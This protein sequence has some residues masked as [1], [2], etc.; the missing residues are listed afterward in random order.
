MNTYTPDLWC[1]LKT[2]NAS[3]TD[4]AYKILGSWYGGYLNGDSWKLSSG[5]MLAKLDGEY[6]SLVQYSGSTYRVHKNNYGTSGYTSS[7]LAS[8]LADTE[9]DKYG[10]IEL[11]TE[12][13]AFEYIYSL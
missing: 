2:T 12:A 1:V 10:T 8:R 11:L 4:T 5:T 6:I 3:K 9:L 7:L 13:E